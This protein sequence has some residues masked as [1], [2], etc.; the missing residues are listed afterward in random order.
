MFDAIRKLFASA[1]VK[2]NG[3]LQG[4][5][6]LDISALAASLTTLIARHWELRDSPYGTLDLHQYALTE[7]YGS[8][9]VRQWGYDRGVVDVAASLAV[10]RF[11]SSTRGPLTMGCWPTNE[12]IYQAYN[13]VRT[14]KIVYAYDL[15]KLLKV[16]CSK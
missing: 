15:A 1:P 7:L 14:L 11:A 16:E 13:F 4:M 2:R 10:E 9:V 8:P 3:N 5:S 6:T 12:S